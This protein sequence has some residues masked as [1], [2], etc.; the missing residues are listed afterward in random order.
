MGF[1]STLCVFMLFSLFLMGC[2]CQSVEPGTV[3]IGVDPSGVQEDLYH[4]GL[5]LVGPLTDV[6]N[7]SLQTQTYEMAGEDEIHALTSDQLSVD[8]EVTVSFHLAES[9]AIDVYRAY[10]PDYANRTIHPIVRTAVRDAASE[11]TAHD[12]V[13]RRSALQTRMET[14][15][16]DQI[17]STLA[18][19]DLPEGAFVVENVL[20]RNIDLPDSLEVAIAAVQNQLQETA[21]AREALATARAEA[22]RLTATAEG[23]ASA[24][25]TRARADAEANRILAESLTPA[26][27]RARQIELMAAILANDHTR[28][29]MLPAGSTPL[30][31][32]PEN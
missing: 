4:E 13:D 19:R 7:M 14:L 30:F 6:I 20:L 15:V 23:E 5:H 29:L 17:V 3:G 27:L 25:L 28:T 10:S 22:E 11:F 1:K 31:N 21:R 18:A 12:L 9:S 24:R 2:S 32:L 26:V 8:L 16:H